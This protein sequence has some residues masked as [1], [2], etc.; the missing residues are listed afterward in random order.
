MWTARPIFISSTFVDMQAERDYLRTR[1]F[2]ELEER[3][4]AR[5]CHLEWVDLRVGVATA[6][7]RDER[8]RELHVLKVCLAE[9]ARCRPFV[10]VL[11]GD[12]YGWVPAPERVEAAAAEA[13]FA[14]D[15]AGRSVTDLEIDFGAFAFSD[16]I[17]LEQFDS[18]WPIEAFQL[19]NQSL[20][21]G[22][23]A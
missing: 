6:S 17:S 4:R 8:T 7:Q 11:I 10:V 21:V 22:G 19:I 13:G 18:L 12:R 14:A 9:V 23:D 16:P 15:I 20:R 2:P 3:L 5:R 1:V